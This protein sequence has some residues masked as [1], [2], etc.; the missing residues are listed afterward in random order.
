M[1]AVG[2]SSLAFTPNGLHY[3][4]FRSVKNHKCKHSVWCHSTRGFTLIRTQRLCSENSRVRPTIPATLAAGSGSSEVGVTPLLSNA[5]DREGAP[6]S[7]KD[8]MNA[9][10]DVILEAV[11]HTLAPSR[12][13]PAVSNFASADGNSSGSIILQAGEERSHV[14]FF[15][16]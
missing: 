2:T 5:F 6:D 14:S 11:G 7:V 8:V 13:P 12:T 4:S 3:A 16:L 9:I 1:F 10:L 15:L